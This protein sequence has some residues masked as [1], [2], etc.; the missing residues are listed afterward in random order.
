MTLLVTF[1][2]VVGA[3]TGFMLNLQSVR[4]GIL[5]ELA[6]ST[7][8]VSEI[9]ELI[10]RDLATREDLEQADLI[11]NYLD[12]INRIR[13]LSVV[14]EGAGPHLDSRFGTLS[15]GGLDA[16]GWFVFM[17]APAA[18]LLDAFS[19][20]GGGVM[21]IWAD[22][23]DEIEE[24]WSEL[25]YVILFRLL[26]LAVFNLILWYFISRWISP[27][28]EIA[29][30]LKSLEQRNFKRKVDTM[31]LPELAI[32][33][34]RINS[35]SEML[36]ASKAE[37]DRLARKALNIQ[38]QERRYLAR[39]L[40]DSLGQSV[41]A[42]K[43][44]AVSIRQRVVSHDPLTAD[45]AASIE[46]IADRAYSSVR[47]MMRDLRP[48]EIDELGVGPA[49]QQMVDDWN[50]HHADTFCRLS[51]DSDYCDLDELLQINIYRIVQEALTNVTKYAQAN[52]VD[53]TLSGKEVI[54]LTISDD[55]KGFDMQVTQS[56]MGMQNLRERVQAM[57]GELAINS[58]VM[59]GVRISITC[60]RRVKLRRRANDR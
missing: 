20:P 44:I 25:R 45:S 14:V 60:P 54:S 34:R 23:A 48:F 28:E 51:M 41:S 19:L 36:D 59:Q 49:L 15:T 27:V 18:R 26:V 46:D 17:V 4:E 31:S 21:Q 40:H 56:G 29:S 32:I 7:V 5:R 39:E 1:L 11:H 42:I 8:L 33:G 38:E 12:R 52:F 58:A 10:Q 9:T 13:H 43:A 22:P 57:Q 50:D 53:V 3:V 30:V 35:L 16:P 55:G 37:A 2:V 47:D 6:S 24:R